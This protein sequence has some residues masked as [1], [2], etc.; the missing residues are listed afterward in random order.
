M[1]IQPAV[2]TPPSQRRT[3]TFEYD[4]RELPALDQV[5]LRG[6][7]DPAT[8]RYD[9]GW[10]EGQSIPMRDD[11]QAGDKVAGDGVYTAQVSLEQGQSQ[12]FRWGAIDG[13]GRWL[14]MR[15]EAL[16]FSIDGPERVTYAPVTTHL[17]GMHRHGE[18]VSFRTWAPRAEG[19]S[20]EIYGAEGRKLE[21]IPME[22]DGQDFK[23]EVPGG[24]PRLEGKTYK[25]G[26]RDARGELVKEYGDPYA[27]YLGGQQRGLERIFV[28]P[29]LGIETGWYDD[30]SKGG[31]N[32]ADNPQYGR[33]TVD[34]Y[35]DAD[36]VELV[37]KDESGRQLSK[38]ELLERLGEPRLV[39]YDQASPGDRRDVDVLRN[40]QLANSP[41][42]TPYF[43]TNSVSESGAIEMTKRLSPAT[44]GGWVSVVNNF[45]EL[46]GLRYEFHVHQDG[47]LL[48]DKDGDGQ[49]NADERQ[50]LA[51]NE[52][53][54]RIAARPG[55]ARGARIKAGTFQPRFSDTP[56]KEDDFRR[57]VIYEAH[58]GSFLSHKDNG[59]PATF[60]DMVANLD[61]LDALGVNTI[62]LLPTQEFGGKRDWGYTPD[63]YFAGSDAYGFEMPRDK[64]VEQGLIKPDEQAGQ[65]SVWIDGTDALKFFVDQAHRRGFQVLGDVVYNHTSGRPDGDNPLAAIDGDR[66]SFFSWYGQ[67]QSQ[68]PWGAK[69]AYSEQGV[70]DF[71]TDHAVAQLQEYQFDGLRFDFTQVLHNTGPANEQIEGM[72][73]LRQINRTIGL[74]RPQAYTVAEDFSGNW[75]VGAPLDKSEWQNG[76]LKKGMGF[77]N[78]WNDR[79]RDDIYEVGKG[80]SMDRL[81]DSLVNHHGVSGWDRAVLYAHSHDEVGNSGEW[82]GRAV[83]G[84]KSDAAVL[85]PFPRGV[86]RSVAALTLLGPGVPMLWQGEEFLA[87]NDF[88]HG[89]TSTWGQD[90]DW[91]HFPVTPDILAR[92]QDG[93]VQ[94]LTTRQQEL[95]ARYQTFDASAREK[96]ETDALRAG[97]FQAYQ[98]LVALR[99]SSPAFLADAPIE[100]IYTHNEDRVMAFNRKSGDDSYVVLTNFADKDQPGYQLPLP[101][102]RWKEVF[103]SNSEAYGGTNFG[104]AGRTLSSTDPVVIPAGSTIVLQRV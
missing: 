51:F 55:A 39:D 23:L 47:Q 31:P 19:L 103:N 87:N 99:Q 50:Q 4:A 11:G 92:F 69:P 45:A 20:L 35:L 48:G 78:V 41:N 94:G 38:T 101:Q 52:A 96:A 53:D 21:S 9:A 1:K 54:N 66:Q 28:D 26:L 95:Y 14:V 61:Y 104:N 42:L 56:R 102:G 10:N 24:W 63:Y 46:V 68:T 64:A 49:L 100:R 34:D 12:D 3:V 33:F 77:Q 58:V 16:P 91:L 98:D 8:G 17:Y 15:E 40:W 84:S 2:S 32:Y 6:S 81:M 86:A 5:Q 83:A 59:V 85:S 76:I 88:K 25:F 37:F 36:K 43:W 30:S 71:F 82:I 29:I 70:K 74:V 62:E 7:F 44:G 90:T 27:R 80:G 60:E 22:R 97:H 75:L 67:Y 89:L 18:D 93:Q 13:K 65:E 79:Y 57:F 72:N 73:T